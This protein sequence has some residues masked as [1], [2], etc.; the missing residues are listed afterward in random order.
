VPTRTN[1]TRPGGSRGAKPRRTD[2]PT[3]PPR[4][5]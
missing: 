2:P 3:A 5:G 4:T 1:A